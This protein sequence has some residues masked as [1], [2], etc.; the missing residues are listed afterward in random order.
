MKVLNK[1][2]GCPV[3]SYNALGHLERVDVYAVEESKDIVP[4]GGPNDPS[5]IEWSYDWRTY[6]ERDVDL[7]GRV[8]TEKTYR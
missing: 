3:L 7:Y 4:I 1:K 5:H 2:S 8:Q 6:I